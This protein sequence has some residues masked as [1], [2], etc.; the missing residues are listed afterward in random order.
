MTMALIDIAALMTTPVTMISNSTLS[1]ES[2]M[3]LIA[4]LNTLIMFT[5]C[6]NIKNV[7]GSKEHISR[8][9]AS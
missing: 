9:M 4:A 8:T 1:K 5:V 2:I 7:V 3:Y 6:P